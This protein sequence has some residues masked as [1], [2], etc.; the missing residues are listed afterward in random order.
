MCK[1]LNWVSNIVSKGKGAPFM[2][3]ETNESSWMLFDLA[4]SKRLIVQTRM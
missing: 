4:I 2:E 1:K 3:P